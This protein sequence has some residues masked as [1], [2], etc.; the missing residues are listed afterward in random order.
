[1]KKILPNNYEFKVTFNPNK[2]NDTFVINKQDLKSNCYSILK[3]YWIE[4][5]ANETP[6]ESNSN[7]TTTTTTN[8]QYHQFIYLILMKNEQQDNINL[9]KA[10][11]SLTLFL[12]ERGF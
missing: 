4:I 1:M 2:F 7:T 9:D 12:R 5:I 6:I 10:I 3:F 11:V 8:E